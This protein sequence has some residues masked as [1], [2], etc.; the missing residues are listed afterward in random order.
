MFPLYVR[1]ILNNNVIK[2]K[3]YCFLLL[4]VIFK[5]GIYQRNH[6]GSCNSDVQTP[7]ISKKIP[8]SKH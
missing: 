2:E 3:K 1:C 4:K 6:E 8:G 5:V 7:R